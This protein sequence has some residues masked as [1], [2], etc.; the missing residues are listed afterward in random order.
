MQPTF[1]RGTTTTALLVLVTAGC[2]GGGDDPGTG[3]GT[4]GGGTQN[5]V[6]VRDN[7]FTPGT[8]NVTTGTSVAWTWRGQAVH[9][10]VF[11]DGVRSPQQATG[12]Y[13]RQFTTAGT[14]EYL[15]SIHGAAMAGRV[16]VQ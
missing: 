12:T 13:A 16:V 14:Y 9:D 15:C 10:V 1:V 3:P 8:A 6:D 7:S 11:A 5:A 2:G 4:G